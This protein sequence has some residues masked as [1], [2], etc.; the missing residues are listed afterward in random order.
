[1]RA[2]EK[3]LDVTSYDSDTVINPDGV[4]PLK[5]H[6]LQIVRQYWGTLSA[7]MF[8]LYKAITGGLSWDVAVTPFEILDGGGTLECIVFL[9]YN[10]FTYFAVLNVVTGSFANS[11]LQAAKYKSEL[12]VHN[13]VQEKRRELHRIRGIFE[14]M[15][16]DK[17]G[18]V[19]VQELEAYMR[20]EE[21]QVALESVGVRYEDACLFFKQLDVDGSNEIQV[22]EFLDGVMRLRGNATR[23]DLLSLQMDVRRI[24]NHLAIHED[25]SRG[26]TPIDDAVF[27][28]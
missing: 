3:L 9:M 15:D 25:C 13:A 24:L 28:M 1:M 12:A 11:A 21:A 8:T 10:A 18:N 26:P 23:V 4:D 19:L 6:Q 7:S 5:Q 20:G 22:D 17:S 27:P 16:A 14:D 2:H